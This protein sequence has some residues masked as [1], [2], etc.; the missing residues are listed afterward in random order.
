MRIFQGIP[1]TSGV[2]LPSRRKRVPNT[3]SATRRNIA[4]L[5]IPPI[6]YRFANETIAKYPSSAKVDL[7]VKGGLWQDQF[8]RADFR[9]SKQRRWVRE[10]GRTGPIRRKRDRLCK[11]KKIR[12]R[13][14][15]TG[16]GGWR[17][18]RRRVEIESCWKSIR[19]TSSHFH[20]RSLARFAPANPA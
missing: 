7:N 14:G 5:R 9:V 4:A 6:L 12:R 20:S 10:D 3:K 8:T 13:A 18:M 17:V 15:C 1:T 11:R 19:M 16:G 2:P